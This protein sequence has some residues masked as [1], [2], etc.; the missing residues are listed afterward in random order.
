M[1]KDGW[2]AMLLCM[3]MLIGVLGACGTG[4]ERAVSEATSATEA[5]I[6]TAEAAAPAEKVSVEQSVQEEASETEE[7]V[8]QP[9]WPE[10]PVH[11]SFYKVAHP[12]LIEMVDQGFGMETW[13]VWKWVS[14]NLNISFD[15]QWA[16]MNDAESVYA[17]MF[18]AGDYTDLIYTA[19][20]YYSTG[21]AGLLEDDI[22]IDHL[23]LVKEYCPNMYAKLEEKGIGLYMTADKMAGFFTTEE[24]EA[25]PEQGICIR[26]DWLDQCGLEMPETYDALHDVLVAF[27]DEM[28]ADAALLLNDTAVMQRNSLNAGYNVAA[29]YGSRFNNGADAF[30]VDDGDVKFGPV[31]DGFRQYLSMLANWY[32]EGLIYKDFYMPMTFFD[33]VDPTVAQGETGVFYD[34]VEDFDLIAAMI[35][36]G[37]CEIVGMPTPMVSDGDSYYI[38]A[39]S[40]TSTSPAWSISTACEPEKQKYVAMLIN[41]FYDGAE[42]TLLANYGIEGEAY[43]YNEEGKPQF[44]ELITNNPNGYQTMMCYTLYTCEAQD[45]ILLDNHRAYTGYSDN[46]WAAFEAWL[47]GYEDKKMNYVGSLRAEEETEY[48]QRYAD[49]STCIQEYVCNVITGKVSIEESWDGYVE[50]LNSMGLQECIGYRQHGYDDATQ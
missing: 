50:S 27:R 43:E 47:K 46:Q 12:A 32:A 22:V 8:V 31:E 44:T 5:V 3:A 39:V 36:D 20:E 9:Q 6:E 33:T 37:S 10:E 45:P 7:A 4:T 2:V 35:D 26:Q 1:K 18:A 49:I 17:M 15:M 11:F 41:Y 23:E 40:S 14:E 21:S 34:S 25:Y 19:S 42:G 28:G 48:S 38:G 16:S 30:Y 29:I 13:S 24:Y